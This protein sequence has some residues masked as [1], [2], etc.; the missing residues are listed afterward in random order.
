MESVLRLQLVGVIRHVQNTE[1]IL[2][3]T[4]VSSAAISPNGSAGATLISVN[5]V[6]KNNVQVTMFLGSPKINYQSVKVRRS[7][8]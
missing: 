7:V 1:Q 8:H 5:P 4:S 3:N 6:I 2:L